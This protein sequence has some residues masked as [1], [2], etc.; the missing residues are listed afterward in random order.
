M[1]IKLENDSIELVISS[2]GAEMKSFRKKS[3]DTEYIWT[4]DPEVWGR[5]AP[6]LF[7]IVGRLKEEKYSYSGKEY[8]MHQHGFARDMEFSIDESTS[9]KAVFCFESDEASKDVYPFDF[10]FYISYEL[11]AQAVIIKY[12]VVNKGTGEMLFSI[13]AHPGFN[14]P[15]ING[16]NFEDYYLEFEKQE[17]LS[18][19][20][21][22]GGLISSIKRPVDG[23]GKVISLN[24]KLFKD[25]ALIFEDLKSRTIT[26]KSKKNDHLVTMF[27]NNFKY[28]GIW[29]KPDDAPFVCIEPWNGIADFEDCSGKL[30]DKTGIIHLPAEDVYEC[31]LMIEID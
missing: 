3:E 29:T 20:V 9:N 4:G 7:P 15:F 30:E 22:S 24:K 21:I 25:D 10:R 17:D 19:Y 8:S 27:I 28:L 2:H 5:H 18:T 11:I 16:E 12:R 14:C 26:L 23:D 31:G 13:G 1:D 6:V